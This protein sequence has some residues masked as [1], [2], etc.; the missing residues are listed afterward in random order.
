M[1][2]QIEDCFKKKK[3]IMSLINIYR[4]FIVLIKK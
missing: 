4:K 2:H 1:D 3:E